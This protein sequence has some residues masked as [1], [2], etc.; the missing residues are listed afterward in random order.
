MTEVKDFFF[1]LIAVEE[2]EEKM[3]VLVENNTNTDEGLDVNEDLDQF[4][5]PLCS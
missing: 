5:N 1:S 2:Q 4:I 3:N